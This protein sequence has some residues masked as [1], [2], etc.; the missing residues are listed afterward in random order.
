MAYEEI[1]EIANSAKRKLKL[2]FGNR[3]DQQLRYN[4]IIKK[5]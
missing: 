1:K 2:N 5:V 3:K 4:E